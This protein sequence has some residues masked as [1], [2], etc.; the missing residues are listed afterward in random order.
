[1][2]E[3]IPVDRLSGLVAD[4]KKSGAD[5]A[6]SHQP[7]SKIAGDFVRAALPEWR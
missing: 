1:L 4:R 6:A 5:D 3:T 2:T 7:G